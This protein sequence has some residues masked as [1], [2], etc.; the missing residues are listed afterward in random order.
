VQACGLGS[1]VLIFDRL[2]GGILD[3]GITANGDDCD[4]LGH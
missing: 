4:F 3:Q 1:L 2:V